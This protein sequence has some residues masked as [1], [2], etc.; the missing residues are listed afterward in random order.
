ME[1][2]FFVIL[3]IIVILLFMLF[4]TRSKKGSRAG[5]GREQAGVQRKT[6]KNRLREEGGASSAALAQQVVLDET[7][8]MI[9][10]LERPDQSEDLKKRIQKGID[11]IFSADPEAASKRGRGLQLEEV[12]P[13]VRKT[14]LRHV[15]RLKPFKAVHQIQKT[16]DDPNT[17]MAQ[18]SKVIVTDPVLSSKILKVANSSY[19]GMQQRVNSIGHALVIIGLLNLKNILYQE[20]L[21]KLLT[22]K[23]FLKDA[24]VETLWEHA[25]LTSICASYLHNL[26]PGLD[27]GTLFTMGL[28]HDV[29]RFVM[30]GLEPVRPAG[31]GFTKIALAEFSIRDEE[32]IF[33]ISHTI[34]GRLA[35]EEWGFSDLMIKTV[36]R[37]HAPSWAETGALS[38]EQN[39]LKY[40]LVLFLSDQ[41]AKLFVDEEKSLL[42]VLPLAPCYHPLVQRKKLLSLLLDTSLFSEVRKAKALMK[43]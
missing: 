37:H 3:V 4:Y 5:S 11:V 26:F 36:E 10:E 19:F 18:I 7:G 34:I 6:G 41:V 30:A 24:T 35:F 17:G 38:P 29:G 31:E 1:G 8:M 16:L 22:I 33:G 12:D 25:T 43:G 20:G 13:E 21:L 14:V 23:D 39:N 32:E 42:P 9:P 40:L 28:L 2:F 15:S 27:K